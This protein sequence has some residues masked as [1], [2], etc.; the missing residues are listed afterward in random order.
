[1]NIWRQECAIHTYIYIRN[2]KNYHLSFWIFTKF[3][4]SYELSKGNYR[5]RRSCL[6]GRP[7]AYAARVHQ[8]NR[9]IAV[10]GADAEEAIVSSTARGACAPIMISFIISFPSLVLYVPR[11]GARMQLFIYFVVHMHGPANVSNSLSFALL[12]SYISNTYRHNPDHNP[13]EILLCF[14]KFLH[15]IAHYYLKAKISFHTCH[16]FEN[17]AKISSLLFAFDCRLWRCNN[18]HVCISINR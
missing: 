12:M 10:T 14:N 5:F 6:R 15:N 18:L 1:M 3:C 4:S 11:T 2:Y 13:S 17:I 16:N 7:S 9:R 8:C